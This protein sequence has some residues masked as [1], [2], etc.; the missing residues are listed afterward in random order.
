MNLLFVCQ[1][2]YPERIGLTDICEELVKRNHNITVLTGLPNYP[3]G[4]VPKEYKFFKKRKENV[5]GVNIRRC[6]EIGRRK[7]KM[8]LGINYISFMISSMFNIVFLGKRF[9][10]VFC[11][12]HSPVTMAMAA[13]LYKKIYKK[14]LVLY[15]FDLWPESL[16]T[17]NINEKSV[18]FKF[19]KRVSKHIY[20]NCDKI[21]ISSK[22][23]KEYFEEVHQIE[24]NKI[25]YIPQHS[26]DFGVNNNKKDD[27]KIHFL[28]A[29]NIGKMQNIEC[30]IKAVNEIKHKEEFVVDIVGY[31]SNYEDLIEMTKKLRLEEKIIFHG[32]KS[33]EELKKYYDN[34]EAMLLTL[35]GNNFVSK[36]L[37][38]KLQ[39]YM[40]TGKPIIASI[41]GAAHEIINESNCGVCVEPDD[42]KALSQ[43][44]YDYIKNKK[45]YEE[46]GINGRKYFEKNFDLITSVD[47]LVKELEKNEKNCTNKCK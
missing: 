46:L 33:K 34:A 21:I 11:Y 13:V 18:I 31:G 27:E 38:L 45:K 3:E 6:F 25:K 35:K 26:I 14:E 10:K 28:F 30:I 43:M 47:K 29:G 37:P 24:S 22:P 1:Y 16:K 4:K 2:Y 17:Y 44:M 39:S 23:F 12:Q 7:G 41:E 8:M 5:N 40:S 36:T 19:I 9:D 32:R 15:C 42:Y 20:K